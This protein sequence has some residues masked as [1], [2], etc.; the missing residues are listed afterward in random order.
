MKVDH[1]VRTPRCIQHKGG[2]PIDDRVAAAA[3]LVSDRAAVPYPGQN[4]TS[5]DSIEFLFIGCK[6]GKG[7]YG[8]WNEQESIR[9]ATRPGGNGRS[10]VDG[11]R[12]SRE[13]VVAQ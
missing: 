9:Q 13:I 11:H 10:Q 4:E 3:F 1:S 5:P 2:G 8:A 6:P 12:Q 7:S